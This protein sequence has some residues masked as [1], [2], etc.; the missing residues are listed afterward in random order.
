MC[1]KT[2]TPLI[3]ESAFQRKVFN[4]MRRVTARRYRKR[5]FVREQLTGYYQEVAQ[6]IPYRDK[7][8]QFM[9]NE[10]GCEL[11]TA[12]KNLYLLR[13]FIRFLQREYDMA[14]FKPAAITPSH[15]RKTRGATAL[16]PG[17]V[18]YRHW[19]VITFFWSVTNI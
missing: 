12:E 4:R 9:V 15:I 18:S 2:L 11:A 19:V 5:L 7:Y 16:L 1:A 8:L 6:D 3:I 17:I 13:Q 14:S 10:R